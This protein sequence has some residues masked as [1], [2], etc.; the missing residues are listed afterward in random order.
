VRSRDGTS[1]LV[2]DR[3][4][5]D[6]PLGR[7]GMGEVWRATDQV[8]GR[9][10]AVKLLLTGGADAQAAD[11]FR[12]EAQTAA[13]L[14][15]PHVVSVYDFGA[16]EDRFY[17][18]MELVD[19]HSLDQELAAYGPV[20]AERAAG[21]GAQ[22]AAGLA[23]AHREGIIHRDIKPAN[24]MLTADGTVKITDFGIARFADD[25]SGTLTATGQVIG[26][27]N[28]LA[29]ERA[30]GHPTGPACDVYAL[31]CVLYELLTGHP[32]FAGESPLAVI[33]QHIDAA[34]VPIGQL[35]PDVPDALADY[36]LRMLAKEPN[37][38]PTTDQVA[39]WLA[40]P[41]VQDDQPQQ[42]TP[43]GTMPMPAPTTILAPTGQSRSHGR[44]GPQPRRTKML[45][46][47][48]AV[49]VFGTA[50]AIGAA[51][52][53]SDGDGASSPTPGSSTSSGTASPSEPSGEVST[54]ETTTPPS[55]QPPSPSHSDGGAHDHPGKGHK[56]DGHGG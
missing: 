26:T 44:G 14:N 17:L 37:Q 41:A 56:K 15:H 54:P 47:I 25:A 4:R 9:A 11:R 2:A 21:I 40:A 38:R 18:V 7:G 51:A 10:V 36:L 8:L 23:A 39:T 31:G 12:L 28:Y 34:P 22:A 29:P 24:I 5:L 53:N 27:G 42:A 50:A 49:V 16:Y 52:W 30:L 35:R 48:A 3:Y 32:P 19:G 43:A 45:I 20:D 13:R 55:S 33:H 1:V 6:E 46:G